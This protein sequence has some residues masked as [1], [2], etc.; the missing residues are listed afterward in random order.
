MIKKILKIT[1]IVFCIVLVLLF[2]Y[3]FG[4][5]RL[6]AKNSLKKTFAAMTTGDYTEDFYYLNSNGVTQKYLDAPELGY[7]VLTKS[8]FDIQDFDLPWNRAEATVEVSVKYPDVYKLYQ[9]LYASADVVYSTEEINKALL[10]ALNNDNNIKYCENS[11]V[12]SVIYRGSHWYLIE[13]EEMLDVYSGGLY[14]E[15]K[16]ALSEMQTE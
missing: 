13:N 8:Q 2:I 1:L 7:A 4:I 14:T 16:K 3:W 12:V 6:L 11:I 5:R 15:Y 9:D 10:N